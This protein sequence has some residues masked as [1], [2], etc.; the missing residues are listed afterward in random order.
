VWGKGGKR[1]KEGNEKGEIRVKEREPLA[2]VYGGNIVMGND[3][4]YWCLQKLKT[5]LRHHENV[6]LKGVCYKITA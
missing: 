3:F 2:E 6:C 4:G 1:K 5:F